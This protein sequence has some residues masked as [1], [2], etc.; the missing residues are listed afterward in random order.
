[1]LSSHLG[2]RKRQRQTDIDGEG[3]CNQDKGL[4]LGELAKVLKNKLKLWCT[5]NY[6]TDF[7]NS[8]P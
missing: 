1:M 6:K 3:V 5:L 7:K 2:E 4:D 8:S